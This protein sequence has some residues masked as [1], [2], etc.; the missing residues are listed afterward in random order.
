MG[1][2]RIAA[3]LGLTQRKESDTQPG[4]QRQPCQYIA[5]SAI[6]AATAIDPQA[7]RLRPLH[8]DCLEKR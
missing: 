5:I 1:L 6:V 3:H 7:L 8:P 2:G 4:L